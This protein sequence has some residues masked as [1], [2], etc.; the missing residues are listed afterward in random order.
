[1]SDP[2]FDPALSYQSNFQ[3]PQPPRRPASVT[4]LG[5]I[6][7]ILGGLAVLCSPFALLPYFIQMG[8]PNPIV[9]AVKNDAG[10][11]GYMIGSIALG[12]VI[13]LVLLCSSIGALMLKEWARKGMLTYAWIAIV[14]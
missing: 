5:I 3:P 14:M 11:F 7:I 8:P 1:M 12:W 9:D 10:L 6:G 13:G 4:T 2:Q